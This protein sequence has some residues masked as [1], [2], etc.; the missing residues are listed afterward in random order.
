MLGSPALTST[1]K[2][3]EG[4]N[5][6]CAVV[7]LVTRAAGTPSWSDSLLSGLVIAS[8]RSVCAAIRLA[9][10]GASGRDRVMGGPVAGFHEAYSQSGAPGWGVERLEAMVYETMVGRATT[11]QS[12]I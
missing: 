1:G 12:P 11:R 7:E 2:E 10:T 6:S 8:G 4:R 3:Y 9:L 5:A